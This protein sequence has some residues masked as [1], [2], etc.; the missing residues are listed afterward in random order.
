MITVYYIRVVRRKANTFR[1]IFSSSHEEAAARTVSI[2]SSQLH[3][4]M[5]SCRKFRFFRPGRTSASLQVSRQRHPPLPAS[6]SSDNEEINCRFR[7]LSIPSIYGFFHTAESRCIVYALELISAK[8]CC[9]LLPSV[10]TL[11][12]GHVQSN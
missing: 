5:N 6:L 1:N 2:S 3:R 8:M 11:R 12:L 7:F 4:G 9:L 10:Q